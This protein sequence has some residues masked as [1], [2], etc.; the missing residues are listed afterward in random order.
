[1]SA[2]SRAPDRSPRERGGGALPARPGGLPKP[3]QGHG[4]I[5]I[6]S[7]RSKP[8]SEGAPHYST[9]NAKQR[10]LDAA[11]DAAERR[12]YESLRICDITDPTGVTR[13]AFYAHFRDKRHCLAEVVDPR[14]A[15]IE[16]MAASA[17]AEQPDWAAHV[18]HAV[19][20]AICERFSS[21]DGTR[22][23]LVAAIT[24]M[25]CESESLNKVKIGALVKRARVPQGD[26]YRQF[27]GKR[28]CFAVAYEVMLD[29][30]AGEI[31]ES[32]GEERTTPLLLRSLGET[33]ASDPV[34]LRLLV[35]EASHLP[36]LESDE[37][38]GAWRGSLAERLGEL[39]G[40]A[41][42]V[43]QDDPQIY[44]AAASVVEV[45][46]SATA[47]GEIAELPAQLEGLTSVLAAL[48]GAGDDTQ[49]L[50]AA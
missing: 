20:E 25:L 19:D 13:Q 50:L 49:S 40:G 6:K 16:R 31:R 29:Q 33:V 26:F 12:G 24:E 9:A 43:D 47:A 38:A 45:I 8:R 22:G 35:I 46:R 28:E 32:L 23:R 4:G 5:R 39:L 21:P 34:R 42:D 41:Q 44:L 11:G 1:M 36:D 48:G 27:S 15:A 14:L 10:M 30:V 37:L 18:M 17:Q 3:P 2:D 7:S